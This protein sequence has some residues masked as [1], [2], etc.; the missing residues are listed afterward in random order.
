MKLTVKRKWYTDTT[1]IG[2]LYIDDRTAPECFTLEDKVREPG[3]KIPGRTAIPAGKYMVKITFSNRFQRD[4]P[5]LLRVLGFT[6][7]RIHPGNTDKDTSGC[8][9][10]GRTRQKDFIGSS[11][12]AFKALFKKLKARQTEGI[13]VE[14]LDQQ[15]QEVAKKKTLRQAFAEILQKLRKLL[16]GK[17]MKKLFLFSCLLLLATTLTGISRDVCYIR[18]DGLAPNGVTQVEGKVIFIKEAGSSWTAC[19]KGDVCTHKNDV[20]EVIT[21]DVD[22]SIPLGSPDAYISEQGLTTTDYFKVDDVD[23]PTKITPE[24]KE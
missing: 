18:V 4:L 17:N 24:A 5:L 13:T 15:D 22:E 7:I 10:V 19:E 2:Q 1:T 9:L 14:I 3:I 11:R 8:L 16:G 12:A 21:I 23:S 20:M 6:G